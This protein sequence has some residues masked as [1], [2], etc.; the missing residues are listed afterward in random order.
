M[1]LIEVLASV[2]ILGVIAAA[3]TG[4]LIIGYK[5]TSAAET[6]LGESNDAQLVGRYLPADVASGASVDSGSATGSGCSSPLPVPGTNLLRLQ[7][8]ETV[9]TQTPPTHTFS[10]SYRLVGSTPGGSLERHFCQDGGPATVIVLARGLTATA[11]AAPPCASVSG[12]RVTLTL[13]ETSGYTYSL[14]AKR[15]AG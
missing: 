7:W 15:R 9:A 12:N 4:A 5:T 6:R 14:S 3:I 1:T 2:A 8:S 10:A 13:T 11:C